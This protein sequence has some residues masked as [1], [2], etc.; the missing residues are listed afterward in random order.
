MGV[1]ELSCVHQ[2][3]LL[4]SKTFSYPSLKTKEQQQTSLISQIL[5]L[6]ISGVT[7]KI[8]EQWFGMKE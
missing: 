3:V 4:T 7:Y 8:L 6:G 2:Q 5:K 1:C